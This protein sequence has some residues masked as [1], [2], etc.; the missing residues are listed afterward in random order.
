MGHLVC[1]WCRVSTLVCFTEP[2]DGVTADA[3]R[4]HLEE[5]KQWLAALERDGRLFAGGPLLDENYRGSGSGMVILRAASEREAR[6]IVDRDPFHARGLRTY[7]L[8]PWQLNEGSFEVTVTLSDGTAT[9][10]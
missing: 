4:T 5:H 2:G 7:R 8:W 1:F 6:D 10:T 9:L 3:L